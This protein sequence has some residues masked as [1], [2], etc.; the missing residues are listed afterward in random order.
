M[1]VQRLKGTYGAGTPDATGDDFNDPN[2]N[3]N[4][5]DNYLFLDSTFVWKIQGMYNLPWGIST[6]L[7]FQHYTGYPYRPTEVFTG[8]NQGSETVALL[9]EGSVR[10]SAVNLAD[11]RISRPFTVRDRWKFEPVA[12]LFNLGNSNTVTGL[13]ASYGPVYLR[14]SAVLNPFV[15]RFGLRLSF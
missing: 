1:T 6:S 8:L 4:R 15:A 3:I 5:F 2:R 12:D 11:L 7:N 14:P 10:L 9:P 13:V